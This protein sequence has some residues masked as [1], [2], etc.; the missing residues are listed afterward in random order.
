[1][2]PIILHAGFLQMAL[3]PDD[4]T[5]RYI[6]AGEHELLRG[7]NAP[8][9]DQ[10]WATV[11]PQISELKVEQGE[12]SFHVTFVAHCRNGVVDFRWKAELTGSADGVVTFDFDGQAL[13]SFLRNRIGFCILH[14]AELQG[15]SC[16]VEHTDGKIERGHFPTAI[17]TGSP[18]VDIRAITHPVAEGLTAE[19][20]MEGDT[21]EMEDQRNWTDASFKTF[22]TPLSQPRPILVEKDTRIHQ[23]VTLR[24]IGRIPPPSVGFT[25]P[26]KAP[27][28][29]QVSV[30]SLLHH[31]VPALGIVW[32]EK[33]PDA[34]VVSSL[35]PLKLSHLRINLWLNDPAHVALLR[36]AADAATELDTALELAVFAADNPVDQFQRLRAELAALAPIPRIARWLVFHEAKDSTQPATLAAARDTL[37]GTAYAAPMGGGSASDSFTELNY[38]PSIAKVADF[39]VHAC[40]PQVHA[41]DEASIIETHAIQGLTARSARILSD[42]RPVVISP[43]TLTRRWRVND[44]GAP[45]GL[46]A[47]LMPYQTDPRHTS[48]FNAA[49]MLGSLSALAREGVASATYFE[50][51]GDNGLF[52]AGGASRPI[53]DVFAVMSSLAGARVVETESSHPLHVSALALN[54]GSQRVLLL[55]NLRGAPQLVRVSGAWGDRTVQIAAYGIAS[56]TF[57]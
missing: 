22:C 56:V 30:G 28:I 10:A 15:T 35:R 20:R 26:W 1:M 55:A 33:N 34:A 44:A 47:N 8:V 4:G 9:R 29:A 31:N 6:M 23:R 53:L 37:G 11:R 16:A 54:S 25:P 17:K 43:I 51:V 24:V 3:F 49:W 5:V 46:P 57:P 14:Q 7:I 45:T 40:N 27:E 19:V 52:S 50:T 39:T 41:F 21:F 18:F 13:K 2:N 32:N 38:N 36:S 12:N 48:G 42:G